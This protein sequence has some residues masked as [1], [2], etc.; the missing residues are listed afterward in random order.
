M[1]VVDV[2]EGAGVAAGEPAAAVAAV[3]GAAGR[4]GDRGGFAAG[5]DDASVAVVAHDH[6]RGVTG[7]AA[8]G[9]GCE[10]GT[11]V[12]FA[13][14]VGVVGEHLRLS[15]DHDL[16]AVA[17][18]TGVRR[19]GRG[20]TRR[21]A[22]VVDVR[23]RVRVG[24]SRG[25]VFVDRFVGDVRAHE[26]DRFEEHRPHF[27]G[28]PELSLERAVVGPVVVQVPGGVAGVRRLEL[29]VLGQDAPVGAHGAFDLRSRGVLGDHHETGFVLRRH[30]AGNCSDLRVAQ[31]ARRERVGDER[32]L[33]ESRGRP[34]PVRDGAQC[35][36]RT[37]SSANANRSD[38][39]I[40][41]IRRADRTRRSAPAI[42]TRPPQDH[43]PTG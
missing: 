42:G 35:R 26:G 28:H 29:L 37:A 40:V 24:R 39:P 15:V 10:G 25:T 33:L 16:I 30:D 17:S 2:G 23:G 34:A 27:G 20:T 13:D 6:D 31:R 4:G 1:D 5:V 36:A 18:L 38:T 14:A 12:E 21:A 41:R 3:H 43:P 32:Q 8:H 22:R 11:V 7:E 9:F 19:R